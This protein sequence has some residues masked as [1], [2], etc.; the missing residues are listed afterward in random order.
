M[1]KQTGKQRQLK[2]IDG[3]CQWTEWNG[4]NYF[5]EARREEGARRREGMPLT[6]E[7]GVE[8]GGA[9]EPEGVDGGLG[10]GAEAADGVEAALLGDGL[11]D[12]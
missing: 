9:E 11:G 8:G 12:G 5:F 10:V 6:E 7:E 3:D 2:T 1:N 4:M